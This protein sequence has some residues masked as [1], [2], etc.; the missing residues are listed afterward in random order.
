MKLDIIKDSVVR[1]HVT[2]IMRDQMSLSTWTGEE[3][4][5]GKGMTGEKLPP[6]L[7]INMYV[8]AL[9]AIISLLK[10]IEENK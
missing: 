2:R 7:A 5:G 8:A 1:D 6:L 10:Y 9:F 4:L 3:L